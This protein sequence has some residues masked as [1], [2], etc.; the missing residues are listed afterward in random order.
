MAFFDN[1]KKTDVRSLENPNA[2][3]S[4]DDFLPITGWSDF[5]SDGGV[6]VNLD[7]AIVKMK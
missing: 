6:T 2:S 5:S 3:V 1:F 4:A 7:N